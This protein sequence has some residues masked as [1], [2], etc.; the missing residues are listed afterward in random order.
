MSNFKPGDRVAAYH[1]GNRIL[2]KIVQV[3]V[4]GALKI[5]SDDDIYSFWAHPKQLRKLKPKPRKVKKSRQVWVNV[6]DD[7]TSAPYQS[8]NDANLKQ[9]SCRLACIPLVLEWEEEQK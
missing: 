4:Y 5:N 2:G 7:Y 6:Y 9:A 8:E 3:G 1:N